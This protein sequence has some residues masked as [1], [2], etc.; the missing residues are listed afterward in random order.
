MLKK[1]LFLC[2][3]NSCRSQM[4]EGFGKMYGKGMEIISAGIEAHGLNPRAV[5][6]MQEAGVDISQQTSDVLTPTMLTDVDLVVTLCGDAKDNCPILPA[7]SAH[8]HWGLEDPA[9]STGSEEEMMNKFRHV[10][11]QIE[12]LVKELMQVQQ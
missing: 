7:G 9:R 2:T 8:R 1:I 6:V 11:N 3:G 4:A 10:R 5:Q 12:Q